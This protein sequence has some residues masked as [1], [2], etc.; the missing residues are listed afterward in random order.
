MHPRDFFISTQGG[1][2]IHQEPSGAITPLSPEC[3]GHGMNCLVMY[4]YLLRVRVLV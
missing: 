2:F 3:L 4:S 1:F